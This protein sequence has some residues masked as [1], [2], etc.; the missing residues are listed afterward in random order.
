M[1]EEKKKTA[2]IEFL[3]I[4]ASFFVIAN[5]VNNPIIF[6]D[7]ISKSWYAT[8]VLF[9]VSK[10]AV[11]IFLM[12]SGGLLLGKNDLKEKYY[13]R[14]VK[15]VITML[16]FS[17]IYYVYFFYDEMKN[18]GHFIKF[19]CGSATIAYWYLFL[20]LGI[21]I[22]LPVLQKIAQSLSKKEIE[23][24]LIISLLINGGVRL[25]SIFT[26]VQIEN[27]FL[28]VLFTPYLGMLFAGYYLEHYFTITKKKIWIAL[29]VFVVIVFLQVI[30]TRYLYSI[31]ANNYM[32]LDDRTTVFISIT[33]ICFY[34]IIKYMFCNIKLSRSM[35]KV[36]VYGGSL[37]FGI[38]LLGDLFLN[39]F[40]P[41][42]KQYY[43]KYNVFIV[44]VV[45]AIS[46]Y[47]WSG[48]C[49]SLIKK[50]PLLK[51]II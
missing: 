33:S 40:L 45:Y 10:I 31:D 16:F 23:M 32:L 30:L 28:E 5:H 29:V 8:I 51:K 38:Y 14:I 3:R 9:Y 17:A 37:T 44:I 12:I 1:L 22:M 6:Y 35:E 46:I 48:L 24:F 21:L 15:F 20:Y 19:F 25:L 49:T 50:I 11:P 41:V 26:D 34:I 4:I 18:V 27:E 13:K 42:F 7:S 2:Y 43:Q 47:L 36:I 39:I